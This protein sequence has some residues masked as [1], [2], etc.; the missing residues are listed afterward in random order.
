[1]KLLLV[2]SMGMLYRGHF[3]MSR[4]PLRAPDG[5]VTSGLH[6]LLTETITL[7]AR[8]SPDAAAAAFDSH[9]PGF[10]NELFP[11]YKAN[12]PETPAELV[13]QALAA[14]A[15]LRALGISTLE[16]PGWEADDLIASAARGAEASG[17][18]VIVL[19]ADKDLLQ[20]VSDRVSVIRPG[21]PGKPQETVGPD[22]VEEVAGA[23]PAHIADLLALAG[24]SS[25]NVPGARGVGPKTASMLVREFGS[26]EDIY[27]HLDS[28]EPG[29]LRRKLLES[30]D[31]VAM[32]LELVRL[33]YDAPGT[34]DPS[35]FLLRPPG[36]E[37]APV[38]ERFGMRALAAKLGLRSAPGEPSPTSPGMEEPRVEPSGDAAGLIRLLSE[39]STPFVEFSPAPSI[40]RA[41]G[42]IAVSGDGEGEDWFFETA[43]EETPP[44][45]IAAILGSGRFLCRDS[46]SFLHAAWSMGVRP[47]PPAGDLGLAAYV[48]DPG[49]PGDSAGGHAR[50][51]CSSARLGLRTLRTL[52][53]RISSDPS[54]SSIYRDLEL[55]L[56]AVLAGMERRGVSL[57]T[58]NLAEMRKGLLSE[59]EGI[60]A[61]AS[62]LIGTRVN[63]RSPAQISAILFDRLGLPRLGKT[64]RGA[65]SS[66]GTVLQNL[67]GAHPFV[68]IVSEHREVSKLLSTYVDRLPSFVSPD[69]GLVHTSFNQAVTA[70]G[71]LSSSDPNLQNIPIRTER[72]RTLRKCFRAPG[73]GEVL[74]SADYSQIELRLLAHLAGEGRLRQA[75]MEDADIH[76]MTALAV[77]GSSGPEQRRRAKEVNFS[78]VYGVSA[79]GLAQRLGLD[80]SSA[81]VIINRYFDAYPEIDSFL[82][83]CISTAESTGET[84]TILG[85]R[86]SFAGLAAAKGTARKAMERMAVNTTVQG[87]AADLM[88]L[89]M[90]RAAKRLGDEVPGSGLVLQV[91][92]EMVASCPGDLAGR[93]ALILKESMEGAMDLEV[94]LRAE[95]GW[96]ADWLAAHA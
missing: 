4:N 10:R 53:D 88:K 2:D 67:A 25:D 12:R 28:V 17:W 69:T 8:L 1:M 30:R 7:L 91:H 80:R 33:R 21:R 19:S 90:L 64:G 78:I 35:S 27:A 43:G 83:A 31:S 16:E 95:T 59:L 36:A 44:A 37:S 14:P 84:R 77:F 29:S 73:R 9:E 46:K 49:S 34:G 38:L 70:T 39:G 40:H 96:G 56:S 89:A 22:R 93:V 15:L 23:P 11:E 51:S 50:A 60:E 65:D 54:L 63:L 13:D 71:R 87:S 81:A 86:R 94:P 66:D 62:K 6:H 79:H 72:G 32:S 85:R 68:G 76:A 47:E 3:A 24:D 52:E 82:R 61:E 5:M 45:G 18:D 26:I 57:D 75:Y 48:L 58:A 55:P 42:E 41:P 74:V 20:L 92:D